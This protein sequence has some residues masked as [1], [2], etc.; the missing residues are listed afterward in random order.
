MVGRELTSVR[1]DAA[2]LRSDLTRGDVADARRVL[3]RDRSLARDAN[4]R[5]SGFLWSIASSVPFAGRSARTVR[6]LAGAADQVTR[7]VAPDLLDA[8][9]TVQAVQQARVGAAVDLRAVVTSTPALDAA[10]RG[11]TG[12][13]QSLDAL[14][15]ATGDSRVDGAL[16]ALSH[17]T[18]V[19]QSAVRRA[20]TAAHLLPSMLGGDG[21][22]RYFLAIQNNAEARGTGGLV[23]AYAI[24]TADHGSVRFESFGSNDD[25]PPPG[26]GFEPA[27]AAGAP[28]D[29]FVEAQRL[30][31]SNLSPHFPAAALAWSAQ[32][33][34]T[35]G[36]RLDGAAAIDP[37]GLAHLLSA[38]GP[39][40]TPDG[41]SVT[42]A[43]AVRLT[44]R[45]E[46]A[47]FADPVTR[48]RYLVEMARAIAGTVENRPRSSTAMLRALR[49]MVDDG[50]LHLW[51]AHL[52]EESLLSATPLG[53]TLSAATGPFAEL[54]V[55]NA[56]G[57]KL[58]YYLDRDV[59]YALGPCRDG[60]RSTT[61]RVTLHNDAP[62][63]GLPQYV[64]ARSDAGGGQRPV[65]S[66]KLRVSVYAMIGARLSGAT[67]DGRPILV[68]PGIDQGH[69]VFSTMVEIGAG[70]I[71]VLRLRLDE[72]A[73][74]VAARVAVQPLAR[75][76]HT[77]VSDAGCQ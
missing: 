44:E 67:L 62:G 51:S 11:L 61:V 48:K 38:I 9:A 43:D 7:V 77:T 65:G 68:S 22:R 5:V 19:L 23:G 54:V 10:L 55:N 76:Q 3:E 4:Q 16:A 21:M 29:R 45:D 14:P 42:S 26:A 28:F 25:I 8:A 1:A 20:D 32:W 57:T 47:R 73:V 30:A 33:E 53:G 72:P 17:Q 64:V 37:V 24:V 27:I 58:D 63:S 15:H 39:V 18:T 36:E 31:E 2:R 46:Y 71:R 50:R 66:N 52:R 40:S 41:G 74:H 69:P 75:P 70:E 35:T 49:A 13:A 60:R 12:I 56:A 59:D 34:R 6:G